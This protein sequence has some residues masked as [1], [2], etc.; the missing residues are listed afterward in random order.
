[1]ARQEKHSRRRNKSEVEGVIASDSEAE[2]EAPIGAAA[3]RQAV[4]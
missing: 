2:L 1:M 4:E 3:L